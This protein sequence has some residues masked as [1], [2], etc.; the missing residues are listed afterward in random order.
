MSL[1]D[2]AAVRVVSQLTG[3]LHPVVVPLPDLATALHCQVRGDGAA[4]IVNKTTPMPPVS[5]AKIRRRLASDFD[6]QE[7]ERW[8]GMG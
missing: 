5:D 2:I 7:P 8:D 1:I 4:V 3:R 6:Q